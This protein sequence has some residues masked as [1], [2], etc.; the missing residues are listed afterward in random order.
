M[1][2]TFF[3]NYFNA[4]QLPLA[5]E[6]CA[7]E[8]VDYSFVSLMHTEG[9]VG[10]DSLDAIYPFVLREYEGTDQADEAMRRAIEDDVVVFGD[11]A[12]KEQYV[13]AR[14][15]T[16]KMFFRYAERLLKRGDWWRF[17]PPKRYR[18]WDRFGRYINSNMYVL[19]ASAYTARDLS[20]FGFP[21]SKC[22]KWGYFP[23]VAINDAQYALLSSQ[24]SRCVNT[25]CSV[26]R[27]IPLKRVDMQLQA[28]GLLKQEGFDLHLRIAGDGPERHRLECL[29]IDLGISDRVHF[30]GERSHEDALLLMSDSSI[31]LA[32]SNR[33][34]GWGATINEAMAMGCCVI[35]SSEM[36]SVPFLIRDGVN[37]LSFDGGCESLASKLR[38]VATHPDDLRLMGKN[39]VETVST[40]WSAASAAVNLARVAK[41]QMDRRSFL[42]EKGP[43][44][45]A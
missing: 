22:L 9:A 34:E 2:L 33:S 20:M 35:A 23:Q 36:G 7:M 10:R 17:V 1:R 28:L 19:C 37:G 39:A 6:F 41:A 27:L 29:A 13:R 8:G 24:K 15:K 32:T 16:G 45:R 5:L 3:S 12:G 25:V 21:R 11:M 38:F 30:L 43:L 26:Q 18:T 42:P 31:F 14:A 44:S 40:D 4:H